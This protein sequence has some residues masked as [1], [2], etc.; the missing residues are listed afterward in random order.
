[1][2]QLDQRKILWRDIDRLHQN[3]QGPWILMGD[4]NDVLRVMDRLG[5]RI[6]TES[7]F[8]DLENMMTIVG[9][10]EMDSLRDHYTWS[11]KQLDNP[12]YSR[13]DRVLGNLD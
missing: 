3:Q 7:E 11:N 12:I 1:M 13:I 4:F 9:H 8:V 5:G 6:V 2:N 10:S